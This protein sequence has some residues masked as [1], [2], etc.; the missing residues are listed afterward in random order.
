MLKRTAIVATAAAL[1]LPGVVLSGTPATAQL[2][3]F[4]Y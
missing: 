1:A 4:K 3:E 2:K